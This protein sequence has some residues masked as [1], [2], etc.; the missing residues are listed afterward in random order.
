VLREPVL[1]VGEQAERESARTPQELVH[2]RLPVDRH[3]DQR[4]LDR[5]RDQRA[6]RQAQL[7]AVRVDGQHSDAV[8]EP[9]HQ[10]A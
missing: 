8:R 6:H 1:P 2:R 5:Q 4:R 7:L 3:A 9:P 10:I